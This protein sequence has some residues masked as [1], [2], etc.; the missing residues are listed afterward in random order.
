MLKN[1]HVLAVIYLVCVKTHPR[2]NLK[3]FNTKFGPQWKDWPSSFQWRQIWALF[4]KLLALI[5][6]WNCVKGS[7]ITKTVKH[8][9]F[10]RCE[11]EARNCLQRNCF[12]I[13]SFTEYLGEALVFLW[14]SA[15][16]EKYN[17]CKW[18]LLV[19][20]KFSFQKED[21]ALGNKVLRFLWYFLL[22]KDPKS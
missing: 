7:R 9:K 1:S 12:Y 6:G 15:L 8:L 14:N 11:L 4:F 10:E 16:Q 17:F 20:R 19:L 18:F 22:S 3:G 13:Q 21:W 5:L 2:S